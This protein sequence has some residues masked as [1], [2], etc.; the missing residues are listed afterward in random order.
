V[1][2]AQVHSRWAHVQGEGGAACWGGAGRGCGS[3]AG[4]QQLSTRERRG[5]G[6]WHCRGHDHSSAFKRACPSCSHWLTHALTPSLMRTLTRTRACLHA[7]MLAYTCARTTYTHP[8][9]HTHTLTLTLTHTLAHAHACTRTRS[10]THSHTHTHTHTHTRTRS[11]KPSRGSPLR[12]RMQAPSIG[13][14][15][16]AGQGV[17]LVG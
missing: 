11:G 13:P 9:T 12:L 1:V 2:P 15:A 14:A 4:A 7:H 17:Q 5:W 16:F 6:T 3:C 8:H 10:H